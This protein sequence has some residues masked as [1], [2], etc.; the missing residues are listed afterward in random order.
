[1]AACF[2]ASEALSP[3]SSSVST[4]RNAVCADVVGLKDGAHPVVLVLGNGVVHM[5]MALGAVHGQAEKGAR[6]M[7]EGIFQPLLATEELEIA[8]QEAGR[9]QRIR[10]LRAQFVR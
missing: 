2:H 10:I 8:R 1:M 9:P 3:E 7:V 6:S 5:V 4:F